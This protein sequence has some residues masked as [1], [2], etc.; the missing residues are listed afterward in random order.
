[1]RLNALSCFCR[2]RKAHWRYAY[3]L[4]LAGY[5]PESFSQSALP[6]DIRAD[7]LRAQI[8]REAKGDGKGHQDYA[9]ILKDVDEYKTLDVPIPPPILLVEAKAAHVKSD[10][11]RA[12][13]ALESFM[14]VA[15][16][17]STEYKQAVDLY[18]DYQADAEPGRKMLRDKITNQPL[19]CENLEHHFSTKQGDLESNGVAS[20]TISNRIPNALAVVNFEWELCNWADHDN[21]FTH[22]AARIVLSPN[23]TYDKAHL[24]QFGTASATDSDVTVPSDPRSGYCGSKRLSFG[25]PVHN[26]PP[27]KY[28]AI[29][30]GLS[31]G[32]EFFWVAP[33]EP[34]VVLP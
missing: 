9:A 17:K 13:E 20:L 33:K 34:V 12:I 14:V 24:L 21:K 5:L 1:M 32:R 18:P 25:G 10:P 16:K 28:C 29:I 22:M 4:L 7:I 19:N 8:V 6:D 27:G 23:E 11:I 31:D 26:P 30:I 15:D 3:L 2:G